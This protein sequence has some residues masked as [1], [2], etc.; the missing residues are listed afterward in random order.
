MQ[1]ILPCTLIVIAV[2]STFNQL[3]NQ[4][5]DCLLTPF[6]VPLTLAFLTCPTDLAIRRYVDVPCSV[7]STLNSAVRVPLVCHQWTVDLIAFHWHVA[8]KTSTLYYF[9]VLINSMRTLAHITALLFLFPLIILYPTLPYVHGTS[10]RPTASWHWPSGGT[11]SCPS[12]LSMCHHVPFAL[13]T[14]CPLF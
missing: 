3:L 1:L 6:L 10:T 11:W 9:L 2:S 5:T 14:S 4:C 12:L 7:C 8:R 13:S